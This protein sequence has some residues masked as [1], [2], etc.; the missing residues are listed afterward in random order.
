MSE[1][2]ANSISQHLGWADAE[3]CLSEPDPEKA[4]YRCVWNFPL[5]S[6]EAHAAFEQLTNQVRA[7]FVGLAV[8]STDPAVNHP[9]F[10]AAHRWENSQ[11][12]AN[13]SLKNKSALRQTLVTLRVEGFPRETADTLE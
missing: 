6:S 2:R 12:A 1:N 7:C 11:G 10:Y 9:D 13:V 4:S 8:E 3:S 5:G